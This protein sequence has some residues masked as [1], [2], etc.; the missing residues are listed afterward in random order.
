MSYIDYSGQNS[1][2]GIIYQEIRSGKFKDA[3]DPDK[4]LTAEE[5]ALLQ[6]DTDIIH[7]NFI[8]AIARNR[9]LEIGQVRA[10]ADGSTMLGQ[11]A[12]DNGLIDEIGSY[13][14]VSDYLRETLNIDPNI[15]W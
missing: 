1:E 10:L 12:L 7:E 3:G 14:E 9:S 15:C 4:P 11:M 2:E 13:K 5:K 6:R 8:Q